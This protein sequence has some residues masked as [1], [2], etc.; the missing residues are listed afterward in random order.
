MLTENISKHANTP[1]LK[2][3]MLRISFSFKG[4]VFRIPDIYA[5]DLCY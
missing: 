1:H 3:C 4:I 5:I 2:V